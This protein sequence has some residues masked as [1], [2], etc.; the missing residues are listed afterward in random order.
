MHY[1]LAD[2]IEKVVFQ[3]EKILSLFEIGGVRSVNYQDSLHVSAL[4][5]VDRCV[6]QSNSKAGSVP[7]RVVLD[8]RNLVT[9]EMLL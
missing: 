6:S 8:P 3:I 2:Q 5:L 9:R 1:R 7:P 4:A